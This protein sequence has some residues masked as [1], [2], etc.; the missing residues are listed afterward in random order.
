M[1]IICEPLI[2]LRTVEIDSLLAGNIFI[3]I[4]NLPFSDDKSIMAF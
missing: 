2:S 1:N 4:I 3:I